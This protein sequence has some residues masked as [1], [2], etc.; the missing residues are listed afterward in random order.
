MNTSILESNTDFI[1]IKSLSSFWPL[2]T[3]YIKFWASDSMEYKVLIITKEVS[4]ASPQLWTSLQK[5]TGLWSSRCQRPYA[6]S[7]LITSSQSKA[8]DDLLCISSNHFPSRRYAYIISIISET[9]P[10]YCYLKWMERDIEWFVESLSSSDVVRWR[11]G[12]WK[13]CRRWMEVNALTM[14]YIG[15]RI[16]TILKVSNI[17]NVNEYPPA[18]LITIGRVWR[19]T[20]RVIKITATTRQHNMLLGEGAKKSSKSESRYSWSGIP[21]G[22]CRFSLDISQLP[23][24]C[25]GELISP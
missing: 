8:S 5:I 14:T 7:R 12:A 23:L 21:A 17:N 11:R 25:I 4:A 19:K 15:R 18:P 20:R 10:I 16:P 3:L 2:Y 24:K 22:T 1:Q 13:W 9:R 6:A